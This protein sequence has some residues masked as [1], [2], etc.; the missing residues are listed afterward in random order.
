MTTTTTD[1]TLDTLQSSLGL[2]RAVIS[3]LIRQGFVVPSRGSRREYRFSFQDMVLLRTAHRLQQAQ[4]T[5]RK[6]L[7]A[8]ARLKAQ[9]PAELPL[10]GLRISAAGQHVTVREGG[11]EVAVES[12]QLLMDFAVRAAEGGAI[13]LMPTPNETTA[14][15]IECF[16]R[17]VRLEAQ[18]NPAAAE[19]AYREAMASPNGSVDAALNLGVML[20]ESGRVGEAITV[21]RSALVG[22]PDHALLNFN[23]ATALEDAGDSGQALAAYEACLRA[24]PEMADAHFNAGR[25]HEQAGDKTRALRHFSAYRR[26]Q[27]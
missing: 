2:S 5:P 15:S 27:R 20:G 7:R 26:L 22:S 14:S 23:L 3:G 1:Y 18:G 9:L 11:A 10:T 4:I 25:L 12:G 16:D 6:I 13:A 17:G 19:A 24:A 8:L 21:Y